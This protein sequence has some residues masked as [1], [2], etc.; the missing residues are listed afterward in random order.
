MINTR[1]YSPKNRIVLLIEHFHGVLA[2]HLKSNVP[3]VYFFFYTY[4]I[5]P[6]NIIGV[7]WCWPNSINISILK[8]NF[9]YSPD[10]L[11]L[12][13]HLSIT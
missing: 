8:I 12:C 9:K 5:L 1:F 13:L 7:N 10:D 3:D 11:L 2:L 6:L 4:Q